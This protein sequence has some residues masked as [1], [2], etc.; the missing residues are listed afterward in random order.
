[1]NAAQGRA[2]E[3][4][5]S[6]PTLPSISG[7]TLAGACGSASA[8]TLRSPPSPDAGKAARRNWATEQR[9]LIHQ[10][11]ERQWLRSKAKYGY[12]DFSDTERAELRRYF[13]ALTGSGQSG[14][15]GIDKLENML[16]SLGLAADRREVASIVERI[17]GSST[18]E[19]DFE[20]YLEIVR[21]RTDSNIFQVFKAM[22]EGKLGDRNLN[23]QTVISAY[24]RKLILDATGARGAKGEQQELGERILGNFAALQRSRHK[25]HHESHRAEP[26]DAV[27]HTQSTGPAGSPEPSFELGGQAAPL[28][29]LEMV[30][31]GVC[32]EH[33]LVNS[34]PASADGRLRH[35][36]EKPLSPTQVVEAIVRARPGVKA[37]RRTG[38]ARGSTVIVD[39][40]GAL[41]EG[42][43]RRHSTSL[44]MPTKGLVQGGPAEPPA[45]I[46]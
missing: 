15:V 20:Q 8:A 24:R 30:W 25:A 43:S 39:D 1:M 45:L 5:S 38:G 37:A 7:S 42:S 32:R 14:R 22:M 40:T 2:L 35:A 36:L 11:R 34:R 23:F 26:L 4:A 16:I 12:I 9:R 46:N 27:A 44:H 6:V 10:S 21:T 29:K 3:K 18:G 19:L 13:N 17:D 31:R 41:A 28:G 33:G